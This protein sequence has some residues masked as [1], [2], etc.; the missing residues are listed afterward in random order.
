ML[1]EHIGK[2][3]TLFVDEDT[4][5]SGKLSNH[6]P[7]LYQVTGENKHFV[8]YDH[9]INAIFTNDTKIDIIHCYYPLR[10]LTVKG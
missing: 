5:I 8:F 10:L 6:K 1:T 2:I 7:N 4:K 9:E 3:V